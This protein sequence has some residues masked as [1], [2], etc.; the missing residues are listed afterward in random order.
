MI[1]RCSVPQRRPE[2][3]AALAALRSLEDVLEYE[4][5]SAG[6]VEGVRTPDLRLVLGD[7]REVAAEVTMATNRPANELRGAARKMWPMRC[8]ALS[9]EWT[10]RVSDHEIAARDPK[11]RLKDL[12]AAMVP[13]L[14]GVERAGGTAQEM[15]LSARRVL[16]PDPC[17]RDPSLPVAWFFEAR[18]AARPS[19]EGTFEDWVRA[20]I[21]DNCGYWYPPDFVDYAFA[22]LQPRFVYVCRPPV[23]GEAN[24]GGV[25]VDA[26]GMEHGFLVEDVGYLV[27]AVQAAINHK[28]D[29][30][31]LR[32]VGAHKWL[33]VAL[34][35]GNAA[36]QLEACYGPEAE[37]PR[38]ELG[39]AL[40]LLIFDEVW[41]IAKTF[42]GRSL[43]VLRLSG[44]GGEPQSR[45][46]EYAVAGRVP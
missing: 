23:R 42:G 6:R 1:V 2:E 3:I 13:V 35:G 33:V 18:R 44:S 32:E 8:E 45:I 38:P 29:R 9:W 4:W 15:L 21:S 31:Q 28:H 36:S 17:L 46:V 39:D 34:D 22:G 11:R 7:G 41:I 19:W 37:S 10:V 40:D 27:P 12:V 16:N 14:A 25:Y 5:L 24:N 20:Y 30:A 43:V 26:A